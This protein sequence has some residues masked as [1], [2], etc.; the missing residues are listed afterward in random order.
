M[1]TIQLVVYSEYKQQRFFWHAV[2]SSVR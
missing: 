1:T 2:A